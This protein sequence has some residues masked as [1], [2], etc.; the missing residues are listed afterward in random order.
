MTNVVDS[1]DAGPL[2]DRIDY[3]WEIVVADLVPTK[4]PILFGVG[5]PIT[6]RSRV[7]VPAGVPKPYIVAQVVKQKGF[8][9]ISE[10]NN[11]DG[12]DQ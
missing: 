10:T 7:G 9:E 12:I 3:G 5:L 11:I 2:Q 4:V 6:M 1:V 8:R